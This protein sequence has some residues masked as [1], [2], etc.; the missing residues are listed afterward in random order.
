MKS[1]CK[2]VHSIFTVAENLFGSFLFWKELLA[3]ISRNA[4]KFEEKFI[5]ISSYRLRV[6][7]VYYALL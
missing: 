5:K 4:T 2:K 6:D 1:S 3:T 7:H